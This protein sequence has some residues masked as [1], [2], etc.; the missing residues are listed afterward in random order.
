MMYCGHEFFKAEVLDEALETVATVLDGTDAKCE[1][2]GIM[3]TPVLYA[4][5]KIKDGYPR[6]DGKRF[7]MSYLPDRIK[8]LESTKQIIK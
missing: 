7:N 1:R 4:A 5:E 6:V 3:G 8:A 2:I